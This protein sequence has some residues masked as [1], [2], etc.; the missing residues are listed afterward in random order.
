M[1]RLA[2]PVNTDSLLGPLG[3]QCQ[4]AEAPHHLGPVAAEMVAALAVLG[5][6]MEAAAAALVPVRARVRL[7]V[8]TAAQVS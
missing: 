5:M 8:E 7:R 6:A 2:P 3:F 1:G 4:V